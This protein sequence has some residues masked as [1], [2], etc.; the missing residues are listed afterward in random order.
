MTASNEQLQQTFTT[1]ERDGVIFIAFLK[2]VIDEDE[3]VRRSELAVQSV[4]DILDGHKDV[5]FKVLIDMTKMG[6]SH[7]SPRAHK[8]Y[9]DALKRSQITHV[10]IVGNFERQLKVLSFI[11]PFIVGEGRK[12]SWFSNNAEA[13]LWLEKM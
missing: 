13:Q 4:Y 2:Q 8:I 10:A 1:S 5:H 6:E 12:V 9:L 11:T 3:N 7:I